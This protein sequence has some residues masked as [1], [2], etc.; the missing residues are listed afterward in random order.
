VLGSL[1]AGFYLLRVHDMAVATGVAV[2]IN[3]AVS[4]SAVA[5]AWRAPRAA[6]AAE[7]AQDVA[8][9]RPVVFAA[10]AR[11]IYIVIAL[12]GL[13]ALGAQVVWTRLLSLL[14]GGTVY[15]FS[16]IVGV[17]L[18]GLGIGSAAGSLLART[19]VP[20]R[21][22]LASCQLLLVPAIAWTAF[23]ICRTMPYW[24]IIPTVSASP[25]SVMQL[26][27]VRVTWA[28]LPATIL[29]GAS[30]PLAVAA[31]SPGA[32]DPGGLVAGVYAANTVGAVL[33]ATLV[34]VALVPAAGTQNA[35]RLLI[36]LAGVAALLLVPRALPRRRA[37]W[38]A[39]PALLA[40]VLIVTV[41]PVPPVLIAYGR[42]SA[43]T[44]RLP[45]VLYV[46]EGLNSSVAVTE[47]DDGQ[48]RHFHVSGKV[49]AGTRLQDMQLQRML[50]HLSA[51]LHERPRSVLVVGFGA[52]VTAGSF[53]T[54]PS[55]ERIVICEIE[56]LIPR[57]V[58]RYFKNVN[59]DVLTDP[60]VELVHDDA[61]H[62]LLTTDE[63]FDVIS[64]DPIHPWVKGS[65]AL[66][67]KE[68]FELAE[69]HL[70]PGGVI[71]QWVPLYQS[72]TST[73][74]SE[75]ATFFEVFSGGAVWSNYFDG[76]GY[77][78]VLTGS[79]GPLRI[80]LDRL[81]QRFQAADHEYVRRSLGNVGF[82]STADLL[83][84]YTVSA[85]DLQA[86]LSDAEINR[87]RNLRLMYLAG[88]GLNLLQNREIHEEMAR[89]GRFPEEMFTGSEAS[90]R[91]MRERLARREQ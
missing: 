2:A 54:H 12:S 60:R 26:D 74:K 48:T 79:R 33:G 56:P 80:D 71:T 86:W 11:A 55:I 51:L 61:R 43:A 81:E 1:L 75:L 8:P 30:F 3:G 73:V 22:A 76:A 69:R 65:A 41:P 78:V 52:G 16:I 6:A 10:G 89:F 25:W 40:V 31:A 50:G 77:D 23:M 4:L 70:N 83:G 63:R 13:T 88:L 84:R 67:T 9:S 32:R 36:A 64:S 68:Y 82:F 87:D 46:G 27:L 49:E 35:A 90:T 72:N 5:L 7:R 66:Y 53:I 42:F 15:T 20:P 18:A 19:S 14:L 57:V 59:Y 39:A 29:W 62:Y 17:F 21:V 38:L 47:E 44:H 28:I 34:G 45:K 37:A 24:P 58:S 85:A 91:D